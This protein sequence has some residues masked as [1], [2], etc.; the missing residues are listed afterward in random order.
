MPIK[1]KYYILLFI[2]FFLLFYSESLDV[3]GM[4]IS[5]LWKIPLACYLAFY[6]FQ[7]R[8]LPTPKWAQFQYWSSLKH[9]VNA[10]DVTK[11]MP[12]VQEMFKFAFLPLLFNCLNNKPWKTEALKKILL[13]VSQ[14]FILTNI[15][16][17]LGLQTIKR[18]HDYGNFVAYAGIFRNQHGMTIVMAICIVVILNEFKSGRFQNKASK[19]YNVCLIA[20]ASYAMYLGFARTGWLMFLLATLVLFFPKNTSVKQWIGIVSVSFVLLTGFA[21]LFNTDQRFHDRI[22]GNDLQTHKQINIDSG[23]SEYMAIALD[24]YAHGSIPELLIGV[25]HEEITEVIKAKTGMKIGAHNGFVDMLA[26]NGIVGLGLMLFFAFSL[27]AFIWQRK[28]CPTAKLA[29]AMW[30]MYM[31]FQTTQG[32]HMFHSDFLYALIFCVLEREYQTS[33][34]QEILSEDA[35]H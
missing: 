10:G 9:L 32:G 34:E 28:K 3:G 7:H 26:A 1:I 16:F 22:V 31:S 12:N 18:G 29:I 5:Q 4:S 27:L 15:P 2:P 30:M 11:F 14:Y 20:L 19:F 21:Y 25:S 17:M 8:H 23:R 13:A 35:K 24:R 6:L 33:E